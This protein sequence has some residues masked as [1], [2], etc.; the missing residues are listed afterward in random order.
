VNTEYPHVVN[1][2]QRFNVAPEAAAAGAYRALAALLPTAALPTPMAFLLRVMWALTGVQAAGVALL[3]VALL[4]WGDISAAAATAP[5][6][7]SAPGKGSADAGRSCAAW[8]APT[9]AAAAA[10]WCFACNVRVVTRTFSNPMLREGFALPCLWPQLA[11]VVCFVRR[12][13]AGGSPWASRSTL[14]LAC[15]LSAAFMLAWQFGAFALAL[16]LAALH[17]VALLGAVP[18]SAVVAV[19]AVQTAASLAAA[20]LM[21]GNPMLLSSLCL[22]GG[23]GTLVSHALLWR[24][25]HC[26]GAGV[27]V[28]RAAAAAS[29]A[30][31]V[32]AALTAALDLRDDGHVYRILRAKLS[33]PPHSY[34]DFDTAQYLCGSAYGFLPAWVPAALASSGVGPVAAAVA[35]AVLFAAAGAGLQRARA[36][37]AAA[38]AAASAAARVAAPVRA[39]AASPPGAPAAALPPDLP[40]LLYFVVQAGLFAALGVGIMRLM[41]FGTVSLCALAAAATAGPT[42]GCIAAGITAPLGPDAAASG[43]APCSPAPARA[44][45][46]GAPRAARVGLAFHAAGVA[47]AAVL[48]ACGAPLLAKEVALAGTPHG[49]APAVTPLSELVHWLR[50]HTGPGDVIAA[51]PVVSSAI[52]VA[53][54][55]SG[56]VGA[57]PALVVHPHAETPHIRSRYRCAGAG[58]PNGGGAAGTRIGGSAWGGGARQ[59]CICPLCQWGSQSTAPGS[60]KCRT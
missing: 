50:L 25:R 45:S 21:F 5:A 43:P 46:S 18:F 35:A 32:K 7:P 3:A 20:A 60:W 37:R 13:A 52:A 49:G 54:A 53:F 22:L 38:A 1:P 9:L 55:G 24:W 23:A 57:A 30:A 2:L 51:G 14:G 6:T 40:P 47:V 27:R 39:G 59:N 11:A 15:A 26:R 42:L 41:M 10:V 33:W 8:A 16:Q 58:A 31:G 12:A 28:A 56:P 29:L 34:V 36:A 44:R 17:V 19:A 4:P 48:A